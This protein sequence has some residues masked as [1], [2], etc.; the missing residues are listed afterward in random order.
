[1][2]E[3][4]YFIEVAQAL[5]ICNKTTL[6]TVTE[7]VNLDDSHGRILA[8]DLPSL[9]DDPPFD[10][11]AMDG[12]AMRFEDTTD[13]PATLEI[14]GTIQAAGQ[15]DNITVGKGQAVKIMTG[16]PIPNGA[17][18]ILQ[19]ELTSTEDNKV[20]LQQESMKHFIRRKGE[21][22][23]KGEIALSAG[24]YLTPSRVGLCATMG[25][26][27]IPVIKKLKVAIIATGDELKQPGEEIE[28][29]E[30]YESNSFGL[31][32]LIKWL[33]HES[34]RLNCIGDTIDDLRQTLNQASLDHDLI[35]TSGG[36][37]MGE[38]DLVRKIMEEEGDIHFWRVKLRPGSPPLF[39][40]WNNTPIFGLPGNPVSSHVVFRIL[41]APWIRHI[42]QANGPIENRAFA[43]LATKVK[44]TKDCLTLRRVSIEVTDDGLVAHQ[45]IHQGSGNIASMALSEGMVIL[46]PGC[47]YSIGDTVEVMFL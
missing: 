47:E 10:N 13:V 46:Q 24:T 33:G 4:P 26:S 37:S 41:V 16:A 31:S 12:F 42:T 5:E 27:S 30:I 25:Y 15:E 28:R 3:L 18:S 8:V 34:T 20:T 6:Q 22:L 2:G 39:G 36:V 38:W 17:D 29:G 14:I 32:G 7:R 11:S 45:K 40:T 44:P 1:M 23:S 21:N 9:V 19:V 35:L 43:K